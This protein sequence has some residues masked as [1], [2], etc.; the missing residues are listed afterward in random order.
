MDKFV[1][2]RY[3]NNLKSQKDLTDCVSPLLITDT[4]KEAQEAM[5]GQAEEFI[6][7]YKRS[8]TEIPYKFTYTVRE[9]ADE[10]IIYLYC[11]EKLTDK[12]IY[13]I[14]EIAY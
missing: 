8:V 4:M 11:E 6:E 1:I 9:F 7:C 12:I 14:H 3:W 5:R 2:V 10:I 13:L